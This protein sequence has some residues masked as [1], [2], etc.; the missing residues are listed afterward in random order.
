MT[1]EGVAPENGGVLEMLQGRFPPYV[2]LVR[3]HPDVQPV[4]FADFLH[5]RGLDVEAV[6]ELVSRVV[7]REDIT[8]LR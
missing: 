6:D 1:S 5:E 2:A 4:Y 7:M 3:L 8:K